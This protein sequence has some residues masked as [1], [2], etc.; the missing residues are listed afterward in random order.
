MFH[1]YAPNVAFIAA[2]DLLFL[3]LHLFD[4]FSFLTKPNG[5]QIQ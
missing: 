5:C 4:P 1:F 3:A 2:V